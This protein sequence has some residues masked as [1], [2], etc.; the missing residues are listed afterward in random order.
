[1]R[2]LIVTPYHAPAYGFGGPVQIIETQARARSVRAKVLVRRG[3]VDEAASLAQEALQLVLPTDAAAICLCRC[4]RFAN[5]S[6]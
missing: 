6:L 5:M 3:R 1:M 2:L 4:S